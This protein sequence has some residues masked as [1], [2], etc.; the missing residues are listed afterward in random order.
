[1]AFN[2]AES[3][4]L[5]LDEEAYHLLEMLGDPLSL[6][7]IRDRLSERFKRGFSYREIQQILNELIRYEFLELI[8][9][10]VYPLENSI[11]NN[12]VEG[13]LS[14]PETVHLSLTSRCNMDCAFCYEDHGRDEMETEQILGLIDE[15][16]SMGVFQLAIGGGEPLLRADLLEVIRHCNRRGIVPNL[17]TNGSLLT[18][19]M[20]KELNGIVG[21]INLSYNEHLDDGSRLRDVILLLDNEGI[22]TGINI[23]VTHNVVPHVAE[24]ISEF[25]E[26]PVEDIVV[27]RAK[28]G[29]DPAWYKENKLRR[30]DLGDLKEALETYEGRIRVD[31]SLTC[32][33]KDLSP[34][35]LQRNAVYGCVAGIRFCTIKSNGDVSP[36]SFFATED[37][38]AGN[39]LEEGFRD[40]WNE[41]SVF[42]RFRNIG[43][44]LK[45][46]CGSCNIRDY[47]RG[48]RRIALEETGDL[49]SL[50]PLC[51]AGGVR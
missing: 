7:Q 21:Q 9:G 35:I 26:L 31:C 1:M 47:C 6:P 50:D 24:R 46:K 22:R 49:Y 16:S 15:L 43:G 38:R 37:Y 14:A 10:E 51:N 18:K 34:D 42:Q 41:S 13:H 17:T 12:P 3:I 36:C 45:G 4:T 25:A 2:R 23:L 44:M 5:E 29:R 27:L 39:T 19:P 20:I 11:H 8:E 33:M 48:C 30:E 32:L 28:P 40:I